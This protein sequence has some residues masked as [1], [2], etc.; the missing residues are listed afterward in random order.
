MKTRKICQSNH[1]ARNDRILAAF[2]CQKPLDSLALLTYHPATKQ[3]N[4]P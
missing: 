3:G 2:F 4:H 1:R